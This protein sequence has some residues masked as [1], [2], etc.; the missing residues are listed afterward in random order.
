M[1]CH[2]FHLVLSDA[3]FSFVDHLCHVYRV[4]SHMM[5]M[6]PNLGRTN[7]TVF[8]WQEPRRKE[9][10]V[11]YE[12]RKSTWNSGVRKA[13]RRGSAEEEVRR[14][15][16]RVTGPW[17]QISK[18]RRRVDVGYDPSMVTALQHGTWMDEE[19]LRKTCILH[20]KLPAKLLDYFLRSNER[21]I[22]QSRR[23]KKGEAC[24]SL[25]TA[26]LRYIGSRIHAETGCRKVYAGE[27]FE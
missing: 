6:C 11:S 3:D 5:N 17:K 8:T 23:G 24:T 19:D 20:I 16:D 4:I 12:D 26:N 27:V 14:H 2:N 25:F 7:R 22:N 1:Y 21:N 9:G 10:T 13:I 18:Q 15:R